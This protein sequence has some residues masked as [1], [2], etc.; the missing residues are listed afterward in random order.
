MRKF[1]LR[2]FEVNGKWFFRWDNS[3]VPAVCGLTLPLAT[4]RDA[5]SEMQDFVAAEKR[6][7]PWTVLE[8]A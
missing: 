4:R 2:V 8:R 5:E 1:K 7:Y 6:K 3:H